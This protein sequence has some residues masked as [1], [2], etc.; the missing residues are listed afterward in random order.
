MSSYYKTINGKHYDRAM[1]DIADSS[2]NKKRDGVISLADAKKIIG[3][4][5]DAGAITEVEARTMNYIFEHYKFTKTAEAY[6]S[7]FANLEKTEHAAP[8]DETAVID[9]DIFGLKEF[10]AKYYLYF[11]IIA[12]IFVLIYLYSDR[13]ISLFDKPS[14]VKE[15]VKIEQSVE[16][17]K[18]ITPQNVQN[19]AVVDTPGANE[20]IVQPK[21]TLFDIS[22]RLY[23]DPS[24]WKDLYDKNK[25]IIE[26]PSMIF[27]GQK[28]RTDI[29]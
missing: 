5:S 7:N 15:P 6:F 27:P 4:A 21:D 2:V 28:I 20:Y 22:S 11:I 25:D 10:I 17:S 14:E 24:R 18:E 8:K 9:D 23:N 12:L 16:Q 19:K 3:K 1:L 13:L 26:K 29:K